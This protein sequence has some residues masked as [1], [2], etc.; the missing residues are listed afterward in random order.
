VVE[1][2]DLAADVEGYLCGDKTST[3]FASLGY[4]G[5]LGKSCDDSISGKKVMSERLGAGGILR[6]E[7]SAT[8]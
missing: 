1:H 4:D 2:Y 3:S 6:D 8:L 7:T 5:A